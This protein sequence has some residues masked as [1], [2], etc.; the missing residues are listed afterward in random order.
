[1]MTLCTIIFHWDRARN[2]RA[3]DSAS[4]PEELII[5]RELVRLIIKEDR[6]LWLRDFVLSS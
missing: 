2:D 5:K 6:R 4:L 3:L 1:M